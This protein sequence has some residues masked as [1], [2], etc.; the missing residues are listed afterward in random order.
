M[1]I[2]VSSFFTSKGLSDL[3]DVSDFC[4]T[5]LKTDSMMSAL[6]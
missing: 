3:T 5:D 1:R 2:T 4:N 6:R